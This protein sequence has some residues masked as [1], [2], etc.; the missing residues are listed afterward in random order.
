M[1]I[2]RARVCAY[3]VGLVEERQRESVEEFAHVMERLVGN[4]CNSVSVREVLF[5]FCW[6]FR[7]R[8]CE[9]E[10]TGRGSPQTSLAQYQNQQ[11]VDIKD[12]VFTGVYR[13]DFPE[14]QVT[15]NTPRALD[16]Y[17]MDP[18]GF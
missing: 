14:S 16:V 4:Y 2:D 5:Y 8:Y 13:M 12:V 10:G 3:V 7:L 1:D 18:L 6:S 17:R 11:P 9:R 15:D